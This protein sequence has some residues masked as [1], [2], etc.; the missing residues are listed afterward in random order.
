[1]LSLISVEFV[2]DGNKHEVDGVCVC[3]GGLIFA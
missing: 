1:M 2:L 3:G